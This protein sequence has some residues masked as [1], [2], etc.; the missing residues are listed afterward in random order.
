MDSKIAGS[1][2][3]IMVRLDEFHY[4]ISQMNSL[5]YDKTYINDNY[6][7]KSYIN[8]SNFN[9]LF[10]SDKQLLSKIIHRS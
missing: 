8:T 7:D 4:T 9:F 6:Y 5:Y 3:T 1:Y 10:I 2:T